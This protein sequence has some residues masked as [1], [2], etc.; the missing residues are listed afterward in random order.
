MLIEIE[1]IL[2]KE[3][4]T[5]VLVQGDTNTVLAGALSAAKIS[6]THSFTGYRYVLGHV[7]AGLRSYD[8]TMP[9]EL[10]RFIA[11]HLSDLLFAPTQKSG[12]TLAKEGI[13]KDRIFVTGNTVVDAVFHHSDLAEKKL[14]Q[15]FKDK[16]QDFILATLHRQENVDEP[17]RLKNILRG[18]EMTAADLKKQVIMP[19]HPRTR[20]KFKDF[21]I[22]PSKH[23]QVREPVGFLEFLWLERNASLIMTDSG[24]VQEEACI[25]GVPCVTLRT[26]TERP[27][28]IDVGANVLAGV[29][30]EKIFSC[31]KKIIKT[32]RNW[33]NP[34]GDGRSADQIYK[35][36]QTH[37]P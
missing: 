5:H 37:L 28:T 12:E 34:F 30:T 29:K 7:E 25:L 32:E 3:Q 20:A 36:L 17:K 16:H 23:I 22:R 33:E 21:G 18:I 1:K 26:T 9:E 10:N 11:D 14:D 15:G 6:T 24:G 4:P 27:E 31:A 13:P 35:I 2:L 19:L 8:R